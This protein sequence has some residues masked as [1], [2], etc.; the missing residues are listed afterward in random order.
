MNGKENDPRKRGPSS[1]EHMTPDDSKP[2]PLPQSE[3]V[4]QWLRNHDLYLYGIGAGLEQAAGIA[5][6]ELG[7]TVSGGE[8]A[9]LRRELCTEWKRSL[10]D[11]PSAERKLREEHWAALIAFAKQELGGDN[12]DKRHTLASITRKARDAGLICATLTTM[13][14]AIE[15]A[16]LAVPND[17]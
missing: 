15:A 8:L 10:R 1:S 7:I 4:R 5:S 16:G 6:H 12:A 11:V 3:I 2:N 13:R 9:K 14:R 17:R